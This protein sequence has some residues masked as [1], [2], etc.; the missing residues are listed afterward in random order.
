MLPAFRASEPGFHFGLASGLECLIGLAPSLGLA[1]GP[2]RLFFK[3]YHIQFSNNK[4]DFVWQILYA[5]RLYYERNKNYVLQMKLLSSYF[6]I[7]LMGRINL[8]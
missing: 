1:S 5:L 6:L 3:P 8:Q 7:I 4:Q 2:A